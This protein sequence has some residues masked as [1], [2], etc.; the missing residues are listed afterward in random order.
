MSFQYNYPR[1]AVTVDI[2][3]VSNSFPRKVLLIKR[4]RDPFANCWAFPGGFVD[5]QEDLLVAAARE[6]KEETNIE[7]I[8]LTQFKTYGTPYRDPRGHTVSI[9][10]WGEVP[11]TIPF[12]AADDAA[13][14]QWFSLDALP[15]LAFD[16]AM[17]M[18]EFV[19]FKALQDLERRI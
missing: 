7:G 14:A 11:E 4:L 8:S 13:E 2:I 10:Y 6:L 3:L 16:H 5:E 19:K 12:Q 9:V 17:I 18:E 1:P 15:E